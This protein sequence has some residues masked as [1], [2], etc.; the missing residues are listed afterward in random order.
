MIKKDI[1]IPIRSD[2]GHLM[3]GDIQ[4]SEKFYPGYSTIG[5]MKGLAELSGLELGL[6]HKILNH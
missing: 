2:H 3:L 4:L 5:R 1:S 6:R